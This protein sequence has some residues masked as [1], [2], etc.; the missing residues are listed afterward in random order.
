VPVAPRRDV[1]P[2]PRLTARYAATDDLTVKGSAGWY[3]RL[4]TLTE[5]FG[6][7]GFLLG[8]P[9]LRPERGPSGDL[10][11]VWAPAAATGDF[12]RIFLEA[13]VFAHR[14][15]DTIAL[16]SSGGFVARAANLGDTQAYGAELVAAARYARTLSVTAS[17]TR[18]VTEQLAG[19][20]SVEGKPVP[21]EPGHAIEARAEVA[22]RVLDHLGSVSLEAAWQSTSFLDAASLARVPARLLVGAA[23]RVE[24]GGGVSAQLSVA[25]LA[26]TRITHLPLDPPPSPSFT[27]TSTALSD[28]AGFP[29][30]GRSLYLSLDWTY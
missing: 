3:V 10:G 16:V 11:A 7:R 9:G 30:P 19:D 13:D 5:V 23:A 4:P 21:R 6:D 2:S 14:A 1:I 26:D 22:H 20:P 17:Y 25:N 27:E 18:L 12:D 29:L 28:V 8:T 24:V 15:S